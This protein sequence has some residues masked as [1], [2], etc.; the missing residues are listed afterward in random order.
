[1]IVHRFRRFTQIGLLLGMVALCSC[2]HVYHAPSNA[3]LE[4]STKRLSNAV[5]KASNTAERARA[6][7]EAAQA[8]AKKEA[9]TAE[10]LSKQVNDLVRDLPPELR[11]RGEALKKAVQADQSEV[12]EIVTEVYGA[13]L[14][15]V[16]LGK[17]LFEATAAKLQVKVDKQEYYEKADQLA[18]QATKD[19]KALA[20]YR[21]HWFL[22]WVI[23][24]SGIGVSIIFAIVRWGAK[25]SLK[26]GR[27]AA[28]IESGG[29]L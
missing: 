12:G 18:A 26:A 29:I 15:H 20:W 17:D 9:S 22:G 7:V 11:D 19:S 23:F 8:A 13:Q 24:I 2:A 21:L 4:A 1:M 16:Q 28:K 25:W 14:E 27:A 6:H 5:T 10:E 3:K